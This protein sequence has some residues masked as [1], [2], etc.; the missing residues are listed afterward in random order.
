MQSAIPP[1]PAPD[2][3]RGGVDLG[4][5]KI[6]AIVVDGENRIRGQARRPTP[7][8]GGATD[9]IGAIADTLCEAA[10]TA[11]CDARDL[12]GV[13]IGTPGTVDVELGT[14][15]SARNVSG[16]A[17][18]VPLAALVSDELDIPCRLG[19]DVGVALDAEAR[20]GAGANLHSFLG[21]WWGTGIGGGFVIDGRRWLGRGA[22]GEIGHMVAKLGGALCTC[23]R[24]GCVEAYAGRRAMELRAQRLVDRGS[25]TRLFKIARRKGLDRLTSSV[26]A[27][28]L[29]KEDPV[30]VHLIERA[31]R[32]L[33]AGVA[34]AVNLL[35][36]DAVVI[37]G[38]LGTRLGEPIAER[39]AAAMLPHLIVP[40]RPPAVRVSKLGDLSGAIGASLLVVP[41]RLSQRDR[42][43]PGIA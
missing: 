6:Q 21:V 25:S 38:G 29:E 19:N 7:S 11:G 42:I 8:L 15:S 43:A 20:L 22:G 28:A 2:R 41:D 16:F 14:V 36:V 35:D 27:K 31:V 39:I 37:G 9:V 10:S 40:D 33:G 32:A 30:T 18:S 5:T 24:R 23:G 4:G 26:W 13:G 3:L 17:D 12:V 34:S 1:T